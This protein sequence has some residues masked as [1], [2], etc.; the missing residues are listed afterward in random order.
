MKDVFDVVQV[1]VSHFNHNMKKRKTKA[2][3]SVGRLWMDSGKHAI[4][5]LEDCDEYTNPWTHSAGG[6][7]EAPQTIQQRFDSDDCA[8]NE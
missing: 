2:E 1:E 6:Q 7:H 4:S 5:V 8:D 3:Q